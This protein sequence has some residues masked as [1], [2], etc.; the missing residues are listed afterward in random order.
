MISNPDFV[1]QQVR[2]DELYTEKFDGCEW[3]LWKSLCVECA[4]VYDGNSA[5]A[6]RGTC[7]VLEGVAMRRQLR[8]RD[9]RHMLRVG[10]CCHEASTPPP[11]REA[12][13]ACWKVL[14]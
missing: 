5:T 13:A 1:C 14:P 3:Q 11:R 9:E 10:R 2:V 6:T 4:A 7:C 12:R 8:H